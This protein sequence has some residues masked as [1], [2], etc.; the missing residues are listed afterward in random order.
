MVMKRCSGWRCHAAVRRDTQASSTPPNAS[1]RFF[2]MNL[3][4]AL[5]AAQPV[6]SAVLNGALFNVDYGLDHLT[7]TGTN[8]VRF[9]LDTNGNGSRLA[10]SQATLNGEFCAK[11]ITPM[12]PG[13][14]FAMYASTK[15]DPSGDRDEIDLQFMRNNGVDDGSLETDTFFKGEAGLSQ[16]IATGAARIAGAGISYCLA[17]KIGDE[18][19]TE[20]K[21]VW[22]ANGV[23][24]RTMSLTTWTRPLLPIFSY[25]AITNSNAGIVISKLDLVAWAGRFA[26]IGDSTSTVQDVRFTNLASGQ[27]AIP[28]ITIPGAASDPNA[29]PAGAVLMASGTVAVTGGGGVVDNVVKASTNQMPFMATQVSQ[30]ISSQSLPLVAIIALAAVYIF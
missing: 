13:T 15:S 7:F 17:W 3:I 14:V 2:T 8:E 22:S 6:F 19:P 25:W 28:Q 16:R 26:P 20:N 1:H 21:A 4:N 5:L 24:I 29:K 18:D 23:P 10:A 27:T 11:I 12:L 9:R 30:A